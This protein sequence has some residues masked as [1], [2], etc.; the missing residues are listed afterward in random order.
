[1]THTSNLAMTYQYQEKKPLLEVSKQVMGE[2]HPA[3]LSYTNDLALTYQ[4][5]GRFNEALDLQKPL[6]EVSKKVMGEEHPKT[7]TFRHNS[8]MTYHDLEE[9]ETSTQSLKPIVKAPTTFPSSNQT[10]SHSHKATIL[11][12][13]GIAARARDVEKQ[14]AQSRTT[15]KKR[16]SSTAATSSRSQRQHGNNASHLEKDK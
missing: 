10:A 7:L 15:Q 5:L 12:K 6:L 8:A 13:K 11:P 16:F 2:E 4:Y 9:H 14:K 3:T 1:M